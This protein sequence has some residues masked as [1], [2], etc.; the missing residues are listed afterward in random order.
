MTVNDFQA[1]TAG[2]Q[3]RPH[4]QVFTPSRIPDQLKLIGVG[5]SA[6][7]FKIRNEDKV[8]KVFFPNHHDKAHVEALA[9]EKVKGLEHF[10]RLYEKGRNYIVI[11]Y[12]EGMTLFDHLVTG[13]YVKEAYI[14]EVDAAL[15]SAKQRGLNP[16][17]IHLRNIIVST[18]RGREINRSG[19][20]F[21]TRRLPSMGRFET[22]VL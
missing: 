2:I 20:F 21:S 5:R 18:R 3:F 12:I 6:A 22:R 14:R 7:A 10:P 17:D 16:V 13:T 9:Y 15:E 4:K 19:P 11:D 1:V 8:I